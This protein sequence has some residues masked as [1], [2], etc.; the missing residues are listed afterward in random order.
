M[1]SLLDDHFNS[2]SCNN[3]NS[4]GRGEAN[5]LTTSKCVVIQQFMSVALQLSKSLHLRHVPE[6]STTSQV[7]E[8]KSGG[9]VRVWKSE[10]SLL[11]NYTQKL[12]GN[13]DIHSEK[14]GKLR[15]L[16]F[17]GNL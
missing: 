11:V 9:R 8:K 16:R 10:C 2:D 1:F 12:S 7:S 4:P 13:S 14:L 6:S 17:S 5:L 15:F 3:N